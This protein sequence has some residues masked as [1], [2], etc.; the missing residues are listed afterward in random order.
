MLSVQHVY[1][2]EFESLQRDPEICLSRLLSHSSSG[3]CAHYK[4]YVSR[5]Y[6]PVLSLPPLIFSNL[7]AFNCIPTIG[8]ISVENYL[9]EFVNI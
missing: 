1:R 5:S 4:F 6:N 7:K 9:V 2:M 8:P 3:S